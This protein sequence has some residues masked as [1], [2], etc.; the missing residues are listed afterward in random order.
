MPQ[1][2]ETLKKKGKGA[3]RSDSHKRTSQ[4]GGFL[5]GAGCG[6]GGRLEAPAGIQKKVNQIHAL[7]ARVQVRED[8]IY[9]EHRGRTQENKLEL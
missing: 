2:G 9:G 6:V 3:C 4:K 5:C 1:G 7:R 8:G